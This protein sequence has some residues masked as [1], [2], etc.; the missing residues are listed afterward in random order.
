MLQ[1]MN[2]QH[3]APRAHPGPGHRRG[4]DRATSLRASGYPALSVAPTPSQDRLAAS[5]LPSGTE[6]EG[7]MHSAHQR[8]YQC[9]GSPVRRARRPA[10]GD[11]PLGVSLRDGCWHAVVS[12]W[13]GCPIWLGAFGSELAA[14]AAHLRGAVWALGL[15]GDAA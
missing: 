11:L 9:F 2:S 8:Q 7:L 13:D 12:R 6:R 1:V 5:A 15:R 4:V 10:G 14:I 3:I